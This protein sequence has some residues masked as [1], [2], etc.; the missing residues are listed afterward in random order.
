MEEEEV[1]DWGDDLRQ[2][3]EDGEDVVSLAGSEEEARQKQEVSGAAN[4]P[5]A[6]RPA[7]STIKPPSRFSTLPKAE[8][9]GDK[10]SS[11]TS[12]SSKSPT[13]VGPSISLTS[14]VSR[15]SI[16]SAVVAS[17]IS[18][19]SHPSLPPKPSDEITLAAEAASREAR[20]RE[21]ERDRDAILSAAP[22]R[23][24]LTPPP[25]DI[26]PP[27]WAIRESRSTGEKFYYH[28]ESG[29]SSWTKPEFPPTHIHGRSATPPRRSDD[30]RERDDRYRAT[31]D[32]R[33]DRD[34]RRDTDKDKDKVRGRNSGRR[35]RSR[36]GSPGYDSYRPHDSESRQTGTGFNGWDRWR[37]DD[38]EDDRADT[39]P[40]NGRNRDARSGH[41][42][43]FKVPA[44]L[45]SRPDTSYEYPRSPPRQASS[46][47]PA[48]SHD[49]DNLRRR[50][51]STA[52]TDDNHWSPSRG[53]SASPPP[54]SSSK[55]DADAHDVA[56][57]PGS[58]D[59][60]NYREK[61]SQVSSQAP[62]PRKSAHGRSRSR[63]PQRARSSE[64]RSSR[65][66]Q[67]PPLSTLNHH[68]SHHRPSY[69]RFATFVPASYL[70]SQNVITNACMVAAHRQASHKQVNLSTSVLTPQPLSLIAAAMPL[71]ILMR[72]GEHFICCSVTFQLERRVAHNAF[73]LPFA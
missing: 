16:G 46:R 68:P 73:S 6:T 5:S 72:R 57:T 29:T 60:N 34:G 13:R 9:H 51:K 21:R 43:A 32:S 25:A 59:D 69:P 3:D 70:L 33:Y 50:T 7:V 66:H 71:T 31:A 54:Y 63:S 52:R 24:A 39:P 42:A 41:S 53:F 14:I 48:P 12:K 65:R 67:S 44:S 19:S 45:P 10:S 27:G 35:R 38:D 62:A 30:D 36:S 28:T 20:K 64:A 22:L 49:T 23:R 1:L 8:L 15:T 56:R 2:N 4:A 26:L 55:R 18:A 61:V 47:E 40:G 58:E 11:P 17:G 37:P